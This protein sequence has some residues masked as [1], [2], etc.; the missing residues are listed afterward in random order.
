MFRVFL[1]LGLTSFGGPVAHLGYF[2]EEFVAKKRWIGERQFAELLALCQ[3]LPGP[4][5]SQLGFAIGLRRAGYLGA[6][7]AWLAFTL[8]SALLLMLFAAS[9]SFFSGP[10]STGVLTA[11]HAVAVAVVAHAIWG[12]ART[13]TPD[14]RRMVIAVAAA[15]MALLIPSAI[16]QVS[17]ILVGLVAGL[18]CCRTAPADNTQQQSN[19]FA[20]SNAV[21]VSCIAALIGLLTLLPVLASLTGNPIIQMADATSRSGA[22]VFGGGHVMLPLL[23][24]EPAIAASVSTEQFFAGYSAAQAVPGPL[25][26]FAAYL[27]EVARPGGGAVMAIV[28]LIAVFLPGMLLLLGV[29]PFWARLRQMPGATAALSGANAAVVGLLIAAL[30]D[31]LISTGITDVFTL[32]LALVCLAALFFRVPAW[33]V[34]AA[35]AVA[36]A[37]F[38]LLQ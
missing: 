5:S 4:T 29:L 28:A 15:A 8:P 17:A 11:L 13:L 2:R 6:V 10:I 37:V 1:K 30:C 3:F 22:L 26:T 38:S 33:A 16:G 34:V 7:M 14:L 35:G 18:V 20:V 32:L 36:G 23:Q 19:F 24:A 25:F 9:T 31:P 27:G 12:M 21:A